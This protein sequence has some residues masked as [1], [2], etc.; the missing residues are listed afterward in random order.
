MSQTLLRR[1][2]GLATVAA[3][4]A[5]AEP[6]VAPTALSKSPS[7][8][9]AA[10][11]G[12]PFVPNQQKYKD[13]GSHP[14]TGRSGSASLAARALFGKDG[15]TTL[16]MST[17][18]L[19]EPG[20][21]GSIGKVQT[22][23]FTLANELAAVTNEKPHTGATA[24]QML[25][26]LIRD[27]VVQ[28]QA[29]IRGIDG[30]RT[31][32]VTVQ[33]PV[34]LRP[35][36]E[37]S[38]VQAPPRA[39]AGSPPVHVSALVREL[40]GDVGARAT[41]ALSLDGTQV[42]QSE[43]IWVDAG[44]AVTCGFMVAFDAVST[45]GI[46]TLSVSVANVVPGDWDTANNSASTSIE[47]DRDLQMSRSGSAFQRTQTSYNNFEQHYDH[48]YTC[49]LVCFVV[50]D[51]Y[52]EV[53]STIS[54]SYTAALYATSTEEISFPVS[55]AELGITSGGATLDAQAFDNL[56]ATSTFGDATNGGSCAWGVNTGAE[57]HLCGVHSPSGH[58]T[59]LSYTR[60]GGAVT[61]LAYNYRRYDLCYV[62]FP[63]YDIYNRCFNYTNA[64]TYYNNQVLSNTG[65][66]PVQY[67]G[68]FNFHALFR[69]DDFVQFGSDLSF[70]LVETITRNPAYRYCYFYPDV[71]YCYLGGTDVS[72]KN[73]SASAG[74]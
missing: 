28:V 55:H 19:D 32:V 63:P 61:Y 35:D 54:W 41:C 7:L 48:T 27:Q 68:D 53:R 42:D 39:L 60:N 65:A 26:G 74:P 73:G 50:H 56:Q 66:P 15:N 10:D 1:L 37:V 17:G 46:H 14:A 24:S 51:F 58:S 31:D 2:A 40:N 49:G 30:N 29:N 20:A 72:V 6:P 71:N 9:L 5:C 47:V 45:P 16:E 62:Y 22:K 4:A 69:T 36:L 52:T 64:Y 3:L 13:A 43:G 12:G 34:R 18:M 8:R 67:E 11:G 25:T 57:F 33:T 38:N 23:V 59:T 70:P 21:P 44:D